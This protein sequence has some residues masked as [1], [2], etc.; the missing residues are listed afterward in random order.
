MVVLAGARVAGEDHVHGKAGSLE[1]CRRAALLHLQVIRQT[2]HILLDRPKA[3]KAVEFGA[4]FIYS[5]RVLGR[6]QGRQLLL[7]LVVQ[8]E[9]HTLRLCGQGDGAG[10]LCIRLQAVFA[11]GA[12]HFIAAF[13][14]AR[15]A[16]FFGAPGCNI[17]RTSAP[18][19]EGQPK[20]CAHLLGQRIQLLRRQRCKVLA[21]KGAGL[22]HIAHRRHKGRTELICQRVPALAEKKM[23]YLP[24]GVILLTAPVPAPCLH[25]QGCPPCSPDTGWKAVRCPSQQGLQES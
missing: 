5:A 22:A 6:Q 16:L 2:E 18:G 7:G 9:P 14:K 20:A 17:V 4:D 11:Q 19:R 1:A 21:G 25:P 23:R 12:E 24:Q 15:C 13:R 8:A 10:K 3:H